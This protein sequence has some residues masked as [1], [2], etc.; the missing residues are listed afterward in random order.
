[1]KYPNWFNQSTAQENFN[2]FLNGM[3]GQ[4]VQVLQIGAFTGDAS[5]W[6][7]KNI[8]THP[9]A[10][11]TDVD[12]WKGSDEEVHDDFDWDDVERTYDAKIED[13]YE[14]GRLIKVRETSEDF[15]KRNLFTYDFIYVDGAHDAL[16]VFNDGISA[17]D[18]LNEGGILAFDDYTW[19]SGKGDFFNPRDGID[20]V[21]VTHKDDMVILYAGAQVWLQKITQPK[22]LIEG[23]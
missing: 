22:M 10:R 5:K 23:I 8:L 21:Y 1:M 17:W 3:K 9:D 14:S 12:T 13:Y 7:F 6:L 4:P 18:C 2:F 15:F 20:G 11:L 16:S 19:D